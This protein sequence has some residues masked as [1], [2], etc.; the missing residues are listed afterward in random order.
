MTNSK[1]NKQT[2]L[3]KVLTPEFRV[4][5]PHVF[6]AQAPKDSDKLK[7]SVTMLFPKDSDLTGIKEAIKQAKIA[8]FGPHKKDWPDDL[9][10]PVSDGD[11]KKYIDE[12]GKHKEGYKNHWVIKA[13]CNQ[14]QKPGVVDAEVEPI[15]DQAQFYA[16]CYARAHVMATTWEYMKKQGVMFILDHVQKLRDGKAFS[17]K[18]SASEVF[19]PV[20]SGKSKDFSDDDDNVEESEDFI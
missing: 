16:G 6:K 5:Y 13:S 18:K 2:N 10:S 9:E 8:E 17:G 15:I 14:D 20:N 4:S 7:F 11:D 12:N 19:T 1:K 3:C